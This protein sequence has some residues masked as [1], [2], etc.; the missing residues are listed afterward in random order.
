MVPHPS[1]LV[2][3]N[4]RRVSTAESTG[5]DYSSCHRV[6]EDIISRIRAL[7]LSRHHHHPPITPHNSDERGNT[8]DFVAG[9]DFS[10]AK[11]VAKLAYEDTDLLAIPD[12]KRRHRSASPIME[13]RRESSANL[14]TIR[15]PTPPLR[16]ITSAED[17]KA[18]TGPFT[19]PIP[20][21]K[22]RLPKLVLQDKKKQDPELKS[23]I[24]ISR[25][26]PS[27]D[28][29]IH[30]DEL[31]CCPPCEP[32]D[33]KPSKYIDAIS[34][35]PGPGFDIQP[36]DLACF[37]AGCPPSRANCEK[38][39]R[40]RRSVNFR[41]SI[42]QGRTIKADFRAVAEDLKRDV[43]KLG[44]SIQGVP[45]KSPQLVD[46]KDK[47]P[48]LEKKAEDG[49]EL[50]LP[51]KEVKTKLRSR[52]NTKSPIAVS[53]ISP[54]SSGSMDAFPLA[55]HYM[56]LAATES[57]PRFSTTIATNFSLPGY[58]D[59]GKS[60]RASVILRNKLSESSLAY[61]ERKSGQTQS[62][63][64]I[65]SLSQTKDPASQVTVAG[66]AS[67]KPSDPEPTGQVSKE[68]PE[69][70]I[71][72]GPPT[73]TKSDRA[74]IP[75]QLTSKKSSLIAAPAPTTDLAVNSRPP[76]TSLSATRP[77][78]SESIR[79]RASEASLKT[80]SYT[81]SL[82]SGASRTS[83]ARHALLKPSVTETQPLDAGLPVPPIL[84][85]VPVTAIVQK[86]TG[87]EEAQP[88]ERETLD[89]AV[90]GEQASQGTGDNSA[91]DISPPAQAANPNVSNDLP[92]VPADGRGAS[93]V[94][95]RKTAKPIPFA[96]AAAHLSNLQKAR[97]LVDRVRGQIQ[98]VEEQMIKALV[99]PSNSPVQQKDD[100]CG[101]AASK[102]PSS[103]KKQRSALTSSKSHHLEDCL[104][105]KEEKDPFTIPPPA[106]DKPTQDPAKADFSKNHPPNEAQTAA[107]EERASN[108]VPS[109]EADSD[110][111]KVSPE[112]VGETSSNGK[113]I[114]GGPVDAAADQ[115]S[116]A[117]IN[118]AYWGFVPA[119]KEAV[120]DAVEVALRNAVQDIVVPK[121]PEG[122]EA[123]D[124][125]R[126]LMADSLA[127]AA[128]RADDYLRNA[129]LWNHLP[130]N[131]YRDSEGTVIFTGRAS[132]VD[133]RPTSVTARATPDGPSQKQGSRCSSV[134]VKNQENQENQGT[135]GAENALGKYGQIGHVPANFE[136]REDLTVLPG[137]TS[138]GELETV[139]LEND[140][141]F[142]TRENI[143]G[144]KLSKAF[145]K[146]Y[147]PIPT[148][149]SS[150]NH[151]LSPKTS[152][153]NSIS[154]F[155]PKGT[156]EAPVR[157]RSFESLMSKAGRGLRS[158]SSAGSLRSAGSDKLDQTEKFL[159]S[160]LASPLKDESTPMP[161]LP[162][163]RKLSRKNT[164]HWLREL[165]S[166]NGPYET[167]FTTLPP[168]TSKGYEALGR[169]PRSLTAPTGP[170]PDL[171]LGK[172]TEPIIPKPAATK[173]KSV[174]RID[175][176][177]T[178]SK[179]ITDLENLM[180]EALLIARQAAD[181]QDP[182]YTP[183]LLG[184]AMQVLKGGR[185]AETDAEP[186]ARMEA[187]RKQSRMLALRCS[188]NSSDPSIHESLLSYSDSSDYDFE[189]DEEPEQPPKRTITVASIKGPTRHTSGWPPTGRVS[190]PFPPASILPS[191][192]SPTG[193]GSLAMD[194]RFSSAL[195]DRL[196]SADPRSMPTE[197]DIEIRRQSNDPDTAPPRKLSV[198]IPT[199]PRDVS[200]SEHS[201]SSMVQPEFRN[202][203]PFS[204][205][206][207][208]KMEDSRKSS[209]MSPK[210]LSP[211]R[212]S[213]TDGISSSAL[214]K[215]SDDVVLD[216]CGD[217]VAP[218]SKTQ[219][220]PKLTPQ[221]GSLSQNVRDGHSM[222]QHQA[223]ASK[224]ASKAVPSKREVRDYIIQRN[225]PPIT[226]RSS[227]LALRQQAKQQ[228]NLSNA[229]S[230][231]T[232]RT[233]ATGQTY[234]WQDIDSSKM[235][236]EEPMLADETRATST[237]HD[238]IERFMDRDRHGYSH[239]LDGS[240][241]EHSE[242][243][244][245]EVGYGVR[246]R[247]GAQAGGSRLLEGVELQDK[248]DPNL[249]QTTQPVNERKKHVFS[250]GGK[251]HL[252]L[253]SQHLKGF[254]FTRSHKRQ[255]IARDWSPG[256]KRFVA[257]VAC[258]STA[259]IGIL[260]GIYAGETPA[261]QYYIVDFHHYTALG[262][263][264]FFIGLAVP[265]FL[266][267]PLPLLHGRKPY[268]LGAMS[269]AMPLL[270]PQALAVGQ[271]RSPYV[272]I[273]RVG[274]IL[275][276]AFMGFCLG[277]ANMNFLS[278][279]T[280]LFGVS[281]QSQ[282][283]HQEHVDEFDVRRHGGGMGAWLGLWTWC[284]IGSIGFGFMIG[285]V[286]INTLPPA[287]GF[288]VSIAI[289]AFV[290]FLNVLCPEVRRSA[291][292][293]SVAEVVKDDTVSRRLARGEVKMH[294]VQSGPKWWGEEFHYGVMLSKNM[295]RQP[296]FLVM[297][298]YTAW[299]YGQMVLIISVSLFH[300]GDM[301]FVDFE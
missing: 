133:H 190:T 71:L 220:L 138:P 293:R 2:K 248:P 82:L 143:P 150:K 33:A 231:V 196:R 102:K 79:N 266:F 232:G 25:R 23:C 157:K 119:V 91:L 175:P 28:T 225:H 246:Q 205:S 171:Y 115:Q 17:V 178:F 299:I 34:N 130:S 126:K 59:K 104:S 210:R 197:T 1:D 16:T 243:L 108:T 218:C 148:R 63:N 176:S 177:E 204:D 288:Y 276:R 3:G 113:G 116:S 269:L 58:K 174:K 36:A 106:I 105:P 41:E 39:N 61:K 101:L 297:A 235:P 112:S 238:L 10:S 137:V 239:S 160:K 281:L 274:L 155:S 181:N 162:G 131:T 94:P 136:S 283:P 97:E 179:T 169:P 173:S 193:K 75:G 208:G 132:G 144:W 31:D 125:Y 183:T 163:S 47:T 291:F 200:S 166:S 151:V 167:R 262:N 84:S 100:P 83:G 215:E 247:S 250:L 255:A 234:N 95:E 241:A 237:G 145:K 273:W 141:K 87:Q 213:K 123:A 7:I 203:E 201:P 152:A 194:K 224:L 285:A 294:M 90:T 128:Q 117:S 46:A 35:L 29:Q 142:D 140:D 52:Q 211:T 88:G 69:F 223:V 260:V 242:I 149:N 81:P 300:F 57:Q 257:T 216:L 139:P 99:E 277:F 186:K 26:I 8:A 265:T 154:K 259:L 64:G 199:V 230:A 72:E 68:K 74:D 222:E 236:A 32:Q 42:F 124:A 284:S 226:P 65:A 12:T 191:H 263:V 180:N 134:G 21:K 53:P 111:R 66:T 18:T 51:T 278:M 261:I 253:R 275:P 77:L 110:A 212:K 27:N 272:A 56:E 206:M 298:L 202:L 271:F 240:L 120:Q 198:F 96:S 70:S 54:V 9:F 44:L 189:D 103:S 67:D 49:E 85:P 109:E 127:Q 249:P 48:I 62:T 93:P 182:A 165:L 4:L 50:G 118:A 55:A 122:D 146:G 282:N 161:A 13:G 267:W 22:F 37:L 280:D 11:S 251:R 279:L 214:P 43:A 268:I 207:A 5:L 107:A 156:V 168:R 264:F 287:W 188:D 290:M 301:M 15:L 40:R 60:K 86:P 270:F 98:Q 227:S 121:G 252:S 209:K 159:Q 80:K 89:T 184:N 245:F 258:I 19:H 170:V 244:D 254:S 219:P 295:L 228:Q 256:R 289:I 292:R 20:K 147:T 6:D 129:S 24:E 76:E 192:E 187:E 158:I 114:N 73:D 45:V 233:D 153:T 286:I 78:V 14:L 164:V 38:H 92:G 185:K 229:K 296:G 195:V 217:P 30:E 135:A 221:D 172:F